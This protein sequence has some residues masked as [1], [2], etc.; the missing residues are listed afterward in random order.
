MEKSQ[1]ENLVNKIVYNTIFLETNSKLYKLVPA[2]KEQKGLANYV[3][4]TIVSNNKF[5]GFTTREQ[6]NFHLSFRNI[7]NENYDR[8]LKDLEETLDGLKINLYKAIYKQR[9]QKAIRKQIASTEN[10]IQK[11]YNKKHSLDYMLLE[12]HAAIIRYEFL[13]AICIIDVESNKPIYDYNNFW[14]SEDN[15]LQK[16][17]A[18]KE[19]NF[20]SG[21]DIR[22][23]ARTDPFRGMWL[24]AKENVFNIPVHDFSDD[25]KN[26]V[27]YSRMY[28]SV[29]E[30]PERPSDE[31]I[32]DDDMLDGWIILQRKNA[33]KDRK[34]R[35]ADGIL[36][37]KGVSNNGKGGEIFVAAGSSEDA[38][39]VKE[40]NDLNAQRIAKMRS[41]AIAQHGA[42]EEHKLPDVQIELRQ[43][44]MK[45]MA[46][47]RG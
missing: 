38:E 18:C 31:V 30:N 29:Y 7:W 47:R 23:L 35:E 1:R 3:Y 22:Y 12:Y 17:L 24:L 44:A 32:E 37:K 16:F 43:Q 14:I 33:E 8:Q 46:E 9:E 41:E 40:L 45:Q 39:R 42:L 15:I 5:E 10:S 2:T 20:I 25:Q 36:G 34:Q 28:D 27:I 13:T 6:L 19:S 4:D 21:K 26:L 11:L